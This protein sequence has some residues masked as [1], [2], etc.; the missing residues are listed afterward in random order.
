LTIKPA[1][2]VVHKDACREGLSVKRKDSERDRGFAQGVAWAVSTLDYYWGE[3]SLCEQLVRESGININ[4]F[5]RACEP[6]DFK[7]VAKVFRAINRKK[8]T[9]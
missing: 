2:A 8:E 7:A 4:A 3:G 6:H 5:R 9:E 1:A